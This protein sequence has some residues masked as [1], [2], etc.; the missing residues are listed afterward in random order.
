[1]E[2]IYHLVLPEIWARVGDAPY[3]AESLASEGFIHCSFRHQV[4]WAANRFYAA[5]AALVAVEVDAARL[6]S[7]VRSEEADTGDFFPHIYGPLDR[8]AVVAVHPLQRGPDG[9]WV[10]P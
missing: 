3:Q 6:T 7:P 1:M 5:A 10:F 9:R 2:H 4:A 8:S